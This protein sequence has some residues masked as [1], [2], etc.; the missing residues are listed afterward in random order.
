M[1]DGF[2]LEDSRIAILGLGLMGGSLALALK[3]KCAVLYG[4]D[5]DPATV[6]LALTKKVVDEADV[7]PAKLL[8]QADLIILAIPVQGII[9]FIQKL[10]SLRQ[11]PCIVLDVGSTKHDVLDEMSGLPENFDPV[12]GHP[13]CGKEK[14]G[15]ENAEAML[16][17]AAPFVVTALERTTARAT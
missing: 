7:D 17:R 2:K 5:S 13:I 15:L 10:P 16:Y 8:P 11:T 9:T 6:E 3:G 4:I 12:G 14:P 1:E